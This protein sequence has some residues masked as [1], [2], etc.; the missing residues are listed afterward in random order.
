MEDLD[1]YD[2]SES[3]FELQSHDPEF[4]VYT[5]KYNIRIAYIDERRL[6]KSIKQQGGKVTTVLH[7]GKKPMMS[8]QTK[9]KLNDS[10]IVS[11]IVFLTSLGAT[12]YLASSV[13]L[14][15]G[16]EISAVPTA[17][18]LLGGLLIMRKNY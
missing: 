3:F 9:K 7:V 18:S 14:I 12:N 4:V 10:L 5:A 2:K 11:A 17:I 16:I 8:S 15:R 1:G 13:A 6:K